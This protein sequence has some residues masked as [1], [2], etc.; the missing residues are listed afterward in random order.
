MSASD[1]ARTLLTLRLETLDRSL[2]LLIQ[3]LGHTAN[4][5]EGLRQSDQESRQIFAEASDPY[6]VAE[7]LMDF[8]IL[9]LRQLAGLSPPDTAVG[10]LGALISDGEEV[11]EVFRANGLEL[12]EDR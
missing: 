9:A 1:I 8:A 12:E 10:W 11:R 4:D 7:E 3:H 6:L 5:V 2:Q